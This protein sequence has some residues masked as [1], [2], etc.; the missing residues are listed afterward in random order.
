MPQDERVSKRPTKRKISKPPERRKKTRTVHVI[1]DRT[2]YRDE[3]LA[4]VELV[5][6]FTKRF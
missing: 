3:L 4:R 6:F 2:S 5:D 1:N